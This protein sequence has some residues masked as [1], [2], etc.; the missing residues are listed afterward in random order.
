[1]LPIACVLG[2][3]LINVAFRALIDSNAGLFL[4]YASWDKFLAECCLLPEYLS[5][6]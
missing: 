5:S 3:E 4:S 2:L 1:M 6:L